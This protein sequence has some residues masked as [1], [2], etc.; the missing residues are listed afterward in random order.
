V[1]SGSNVFRSRGVQGFGQRAPFGVGALQAF[2]QAMARQQA[3]RLRRDE[4]ERR[5]REREEDRERRERERAED[6]SIRASNR[7]EDVRFR[8]EGREQG[9]SEKALN[10]LLS[11]PPDGKVDQ[12]LPQLRAQGLTTEQEQFGL[13]MLDAKKKQLA[14]EKKRGEAGAATGRVNEQA[15]QGIPDLLAQANAGDPTAGANAQQ[16]LQALINRPGGGGLQGNRGTLAEIAGRVPIA[17]QGL[18]GARAEAEAARFGQLPDALKA[19]EATKDLLSPE[20]LTTARHMARDRSIL[21]TTTES[22]RTLKR[23]EAKGAITPED[24]D[25]FALMGVIASAGGATN[26]S[27]TLSDGTVIEQGGGGVSGSIKD[28]T[29]ARSTIIDLQRSIS[30]VTQMRDSLQA[31]PELFGF[32]ARVQNLAQ[33]AKGFAQSVAD[34]TGNTY[35]VDLVNQGQSVLTQELSRPEGLDPGIKADAKRLGVGVPFKDQV[36]SRLPGAGAFGLSAQVS[37]IEAEQMMMAYALAG[38]FKTG[39]GRLSVAAVNDWKRIVDFKDIR[40][41]EAFDVKLGR[42]LNGLNKRLADE[43]KKASFI[44]GDEG[45]NI[46]ALLN[47]GLQAPQAPAPQQAPQGG[48]AVTYEFDAQGRL[49]PAGP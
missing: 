23:L 16:A 14:L 15:R 44:I 40:G 7:A 13:A 22:E 47:P 8:Q 29:K 6:Q 37:G 30:D 24:R 38:Q 17:Q 2:Q 12:I 9:Q 39:A 3:E 49:V 20:E 33:S 31:H 46:D 4:I 5:R 32:G 41:S 1:G 43:R 11:F 34:T 10:F 25:R 42:L 27:I 48:G 21:G 19:V 36:L 26:M 18:V 45:S 35:F 28:A